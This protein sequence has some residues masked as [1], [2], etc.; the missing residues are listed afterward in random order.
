M[1]FTEKV[2]DLRNNRHYILS[3]L[4]PHLPL[5]RTPTNYTGQ[6][7]QEEEGGGGEEEGEEKKCLLHLVAV[8]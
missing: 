6:T 3:S 2:E 1:Q 8:Q 4:V 7:L 5:P